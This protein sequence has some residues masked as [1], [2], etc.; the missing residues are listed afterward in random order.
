MA[1]LGGGVNSEAG[2]V[3]ENRSLEALGYNLSPAPPLSPSWL[4]EMS[5]LLITGSCH[6]DG[7]QETSET[8]SQNNSFLL[9]LFLSGIHHGDEQLVN[10]KTHQ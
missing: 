8:M 5:I 2:L 1:L 7:S 9:K 10:T 6:Q 3:A 4:H